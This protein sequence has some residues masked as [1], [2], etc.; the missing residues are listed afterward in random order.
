MHTG[1]A[2]NLLLC[3]AGSLTTETITRQVALLC[4]LDI[5]LNVRFESYGT[6]QALSSVDSPY[7]DTEGGGGQLATFRSE[8]ETGLD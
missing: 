8:L 3:V 2:A 7:C 4:N 5:L 1:E 6:L